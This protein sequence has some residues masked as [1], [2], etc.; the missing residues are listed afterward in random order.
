[1]TRLAKF[2]L[3]SITV[4]HVASLFGC[5]R[6][7][8][9]FGDGHLIDNGALAATDR[10]VLNL[11]PIDL[12]Q[13]G[14]KTFQIAN[15]PEVNFVAGIEVSVTPKDRAI[16][17]KQL[18]NVT[19]SIELSDPG[20]KVLF[21]KQSP[22]GTWTWSA[23]VGGHR[24]FVYGRGEPGTYFTPAP[25]TRYTLTLNILEPDRSQAKYTAQLVAKSSGWK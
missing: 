12:T 17:D 24:T 3:G 14:S 1:M 2:I 6:V 10:Y 7:S 18:P 11:G 9:Y 15:L 19:V 16:I 5:Y 21:A 8:Q 4:V 23:P 13:R 25:N 20:G 22:L